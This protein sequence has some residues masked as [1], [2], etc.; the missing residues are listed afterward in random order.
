MKVWTPIQYRDFYDVPRMFLARTHETIY[1][2]DCRFDAAKDVYED[3]DEVFSM[4]ELAEEDLRGSWETLSARA[5][6]SLGKVLVSEVE[7]DS[8]RRAEVN[9][10][11]LQK[12]AGATAPES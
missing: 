1:L 12:L 6:R 3:T 9:L 2:F 4:P 7:F 10:E 5:T 11:L 8:T